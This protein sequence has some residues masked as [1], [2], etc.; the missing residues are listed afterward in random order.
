MGK[1]V[2]IFVEGVSMTI[3]SDVKIDDNKGTSREDKER[4][5]EEKKPVSRGDD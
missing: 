5:S 1:D 3:T 4:S 2:K